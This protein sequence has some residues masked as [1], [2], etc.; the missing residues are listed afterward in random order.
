MRNL[1]LDLKIRAKL[2]GF[3]IRIASPNYC[4]CVYMCMY[5]YMLLYLLQS[6]GTDFVSS[7][8]DR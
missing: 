8:L 3:G 5:V 4:V 1:I 7:K 2:G 6:Y